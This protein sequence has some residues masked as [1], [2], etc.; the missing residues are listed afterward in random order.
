MAVRKPAVPP[1]PEQPR[2][3]PV[4]LRPGGRRAH[5]RHVQVRRP[6]VFGVAVAGAAMFVGSMASSALPDSS[7]E[8]PT[9]LPL[10]VIDVA[11]SPASSMGA[12]TLG[13]TAA[14]PAAT[15]V[16][17]VHLTT[18]RVRVPPSITPLPLGE[19]VRPLDPGPARF[20][21]LTAQESEI[22]SRSTM[23]APSTTTSGERPAP[24]PERPIGDHQPDTSQPAQ[25]VVQPE[26]ATAPTNGSTHHVV[27]SSGSAEDVAAQGSG[28]YDSGRSV[29][30]V[31]SPPSGQA[32]A[33]DGSA[34][35]DSTHQGG[36]HHR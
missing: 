5:R 20:P 36:R 10:G 22:S 28:S 25:P 1:A 34:R 8:H 11:S 19:R 32:T 31:N 33:Q 9:N 35:H 29:G 7:P 4:T 18:Q 15:P 30:H 14:V 2:P 3:V 16:S 21:A 17:D 23:D 13:A 27:E 6:V 26:D 24:A 12:V